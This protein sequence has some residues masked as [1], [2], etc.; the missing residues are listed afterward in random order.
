MKMKKT[1]TQIKPSLSVVVPCYN[2]EKNIPLM[3]GRFIEILP[4][5]I[6]AE[7]VLV[8]NGSTDGSNSQITKLSEK[9]HF[10]RPVHIKKN[11][12]YGFGVWTGLKAAKGEY[13]CWTHAD[14]Q[15]DIK[16]TI[17][18]YNLIMKQ[19][20]PER[21]FVKGSRKKRPF[22]DSFFTLGMSL[23]ETI[24]LGTFLHDINAQPNLFHKSFM[25]K[26]KNPPNNFSFDLYFYYM[27]KTSRYR[28][29]RFPVNF[30]QRIHGSSHWNTSIAGKWKFIKRTVDFTFKL[31]R[32][33]KG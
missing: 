17:T 11:I 21:C 20:E 15:T 8:D 29:I 13:L 10:I 2:E 25:K 5:K 30:R 33:L 18:A 4:K 32:H 16:D 7:L 24:I 23:F 14:M 19:D 27:A 9:H 3:V 31:K 12:G 26:T 28:L 1:T 6:S 22:F